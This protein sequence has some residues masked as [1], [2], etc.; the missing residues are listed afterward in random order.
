MEIRVCFQHYGKT[1]EL[2]FIKK[3]LAKVRDDIRNNLELIGHV[4][5]NPLNLGLIC[6]FSGSV[7]V[8]N[9]MEERGSDF[10]DFY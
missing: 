6:L 7:F 2:I 3:C 9:I 4:G 5:V 10:H 1:D 8:S